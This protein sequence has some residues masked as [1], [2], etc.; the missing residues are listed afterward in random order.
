MKNIFLL[1]IFLGLTTAYSQPIYSQSYPQNYFR[2]PLDIPL[3]LS[4]TFGELR[5]NH[6][7]SGIDIKTQGHTGLKVYAAADGYV[8]R[9]KVSPWGYGNALYI[10]HSNGYTTVYAHLNHYNKRIDSIV[11][12]V[13]YR[14]KSFSFD[15]YPKAGT[16]HVMKSEIIGYSGN[17]GSSGG[18]HLH[19]EI[20]DAASRPINPFLFGVKVPDNIKPTIKALRIYNLPENYNGTVVKEFKFT[21]K[22]T[23]IH[24]NDTITVAGKFYL[25]INSYDKLN[26]AP[27][28][29]GIY[30]YKI[31]VDEE[32]FF[33]FTVERLVFSEKRYINSYIDFDEFYH[34]KNRFQRTYIA[35]GN[36]LSNYKTSV[37]S[38][39][40]K[41][42]D[43]LAHKIKIIVKDYEGNTNIIEFS[44]KKGHVKTPK[45]LN[46]KPNIMY[47]EIN[48][49]SISGAK[50]NIPQGCLYEDIYFNMSETKNPYS[51]YSKLIRVGNPGI[52]LNNY[53]SLSIKA[54]SNL[55][56]ELQS[57][58]ALAS[59]SK[60]NRLI[61]EGG[62]YNDGWVTTKT[63]SF[64]SYYI[65]VDTLSPKIKAENIYNGKYITSLK[66]LNFIITDNLSG[67][68]TYVGTVDG[69]WVLGKYDA[70]RN[71][72][73]FPVDE[74]FP[75]G[76]FKFKLKITD[77]KGNSTEKVF[78][79][80]KS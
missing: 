41:I 61:Y 55:T 26:G 16:I 2:S 12:S 49:Y 11:K 58:A 65:V 59:L 48:S 72:L 24:K 77:G 28:K 60:N 23:P 70:K 34:H 27:N 36:K 54:D 53:V 3:V 33:N 62:R 71:R 9:I 30:S 66:N 47:N 22:N 17:S 63:R 57:K 35:S 6:F 56:S 7:H 69:K 68:D 73:S 25:G 37:N 79:L 21:S 46:P 29:N 31:L 50:I 52:P 13:Q 78:T 20:R 15:Y 10:K 38:G 1:L 14:R 4:G 45:I 75:K 67:V 74:H 18:P 40:I 76:S 80:K 42:S 5:S 8:S 64:G 32:E 44:A 51:S 43:S 19:Y 39:I